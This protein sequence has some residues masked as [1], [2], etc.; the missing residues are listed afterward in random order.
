[1]YS[2][3]HLAWIESAKSL[4]QRR[5]PRWENGYTNAPK[6]DNA[7][8]DFG[9]F[10]ALGGTDMHDK[11]MQ[12]YIKAQDLMTREDGQDLVEYALVASLLS[13]AA[14]AAM[15]TLASAV[16]GAFTA[17]SAKLVVS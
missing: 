13:L 1:V 5:A 8:T 15:G 3:S 16:N 2:R 9:Y 14:T 11:M 10:H 6:Q 12:F 4:I 7:Q 17:I